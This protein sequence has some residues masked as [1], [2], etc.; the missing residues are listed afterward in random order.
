MQ[1]EYKVNV[2]CLGVGAP[3]T[4]IQHINIINSGWKKLHQCLS[5]YIYSD[6][7]SNVFCYLPDETKSSKYRVISSFLPTARLS[8]QGALFFRSRYCDIFNQ[9]PTNYSPWNRISERSKCI[10]LL[11]SMFAPIK[12]SNFNLQKRR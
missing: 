8:Q 2:S 9:S 10:L 11:K 3:M 12:N 1:Y 4:I 6:P 7:F 5:F